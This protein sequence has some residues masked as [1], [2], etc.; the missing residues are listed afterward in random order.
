MAK[1]IQYFVYLFSEKVSLR[2]NFIQ[3]DTTR[4][5]TIQQGGQTNATFRT[6]SK[7]YNVVLIV[8]LVWPGL[9]VTSENE[10]CLIN[11]HVIMLKPDTK[12]II[13]APRLY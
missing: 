13:S 6:T 7:L 3:Q 12:L 9:K 10:L 2:S 11:L 4:Y 5:N 1:R 8:V